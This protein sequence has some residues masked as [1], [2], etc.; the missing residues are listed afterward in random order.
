[1]SL[2]KA[3]EKAQVGRQDTVR[4]YLYAD[5]KIISTFKYT[6]QTRSV[7]VC[8]ERK[9]FSAEG[10]ADSERGENTAAGRAGEVPRM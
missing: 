5:T 8:T 2:E 10:A 3:V 6:K 1:M 7:C 4:I 9:K